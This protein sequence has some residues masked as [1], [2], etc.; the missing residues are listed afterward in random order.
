L[1]GIYSINNNVNGKRY[2]GK[3]KN[4][5]RRIWAHF[6]LLKKELPT[7]AVN[8]HL[9]AAVKKYGIENFS[10]EVLESF[11]ELDD[12]ILADREVFWMEFYNTTDRDFG[13]NLIKDS[14]SRTIVHAETI[15]F[16]KEAMLGEGNPNFGNYWSEEQKQAM[17]EI[18][19]DRHASGIYGEEWRQKIGIAASKVWEDIDLKAQMSR[20]VA[21]A[22]SKYRIYQ[23]DKVTM[24]LV[25]VWE[26]M[27]EIMDEH[28]DYHKIAIYSVANGH[29][30]SYRGYIWKTELK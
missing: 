27:Q 8:R 7:R 25:R 23:Y 21:I 26:N 6:N 19:K 13:Y 22:T 15:A 12:S 28:P 9:F 16:F 14:S 20:N 3:S 17:S 4:I 29:K 2:I 18:A 10:W 11:E 30:K 5:D 1:I 24:E